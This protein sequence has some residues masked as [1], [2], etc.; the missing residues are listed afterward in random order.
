MAN[1]PCNCPPLYVSGPGGVCNPL[2]PGLPQLDCNTK[3][4]PAQQAATYAGTQV[5]GGV[6]PSLFGPIGTVI[7][8]AVPVIAL[9]SFGLILL[10]IGFILLKG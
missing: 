4:N 9:F 8:K 7:T 5:A 3:L 10:I 6:V 2:I 1:Q